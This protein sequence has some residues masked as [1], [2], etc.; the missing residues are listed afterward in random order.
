MLEHHHQPPYELPTSNF[1][2]HVLIV[3]LKD[4]L[5]ELKIGDRFEKT[6]VRQG[7]LS[8]VPAHADFWKIARQDTEFIPIAID[9][10]QLLC[11]LPEVFPDENIE[12][13]PTFSQ[14][15]PFIYAT[16]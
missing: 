5:A 16:A 8:L 2:Q 11:N 13:I 10:R 9:N 12:L 7:N 3:F 15:D 1:Q 6:N 4:V 14:N